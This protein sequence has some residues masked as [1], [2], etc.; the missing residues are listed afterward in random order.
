MFLMESEPQHS[1]LFLSIVLLAIYSF[2]IIV[3]ISVLGWQ[4]EIVIRHRES[5]V[6]KRGYIGWSWTYQLFGWLVP[7]VRGEISIG[8]MHLMIN[9][10]T[11]GIVIFAL[12]RVDTYF[13]LTASLSETYF[14]LLTTGAALYL[15]GYV[16]TVALY[17]LTIVFPF[18]IFHLVMTCIY[19]EQHILR[20]LTTGWELFD[21]DE[22]VLHA[23]Q[24]L[25]IKPKN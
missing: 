17:F 25:G 6:T 3:C 20:H 19:N 16:F 24:K 22:N 5:G 15:E 18:G 9:I 11:N 2:P 23:K 14:Q 7:V 8:F 10:L 1:F 13:G 12:L 4:R 21:T